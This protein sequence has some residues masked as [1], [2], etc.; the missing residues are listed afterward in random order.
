M[1]PTVSRQLRKRAVT[2]EDL[3]AW[4]RDE[5]IP[6]LAEVR[7]GL[8]YKAV[9]NVP[10]FPTDGTSVATTIWKSA[11]LA[12]GTVVR[13][14]ADVI[15]WDG[16]EPCAL[17][18]TGLFFN[19]GPSGPQQMGATTAGYTQ[20]SLGLS[21]DYLIVGNHIELQVD[22]AGNVITWRAV[23]TAQEAP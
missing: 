11:D 17:T 12:V 14:D 1:I 7:Q 9:S 13:L 20:N 15:G 6:F 5:L 8:N 4:T 16:S 23:V 3:G 18:V 22:D 10:A 21:V 19:D 2:T